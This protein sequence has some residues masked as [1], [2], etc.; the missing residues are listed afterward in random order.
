[1]DDLEREILN[2]NEMGTS[3]DKIKNPGAEN[4]E[5]FRDMNTFSRNEKSPNESCQTCNVA[6]N[7]FNI[8]NFVQD[9]ENN[10]DNFD[11][12]ETNPGPSAANQ[13]FNKT[14]E[15]F[16]ENLVNIEDV[17]DDN[18]D[19]LSEED[20]TNYESLNTKIYN[21]LV[22]IKEPLIV[23][24]LFILLNNRDFIALTYKLPFI[25]NF[26]SPYPSLIIRGIILASVIFYLRKLHPD[27][28]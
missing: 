18:E 12:I 28:N 20:D 27:N 21:F 7:K 14:R 13:D 15:D 22:N 25:N 24:L 6:N 17:P 16:T 4:R 8:N 5:L 11:N 2:Y 26:E 19:S 3:I 1:M 10:L 23:I 9:L